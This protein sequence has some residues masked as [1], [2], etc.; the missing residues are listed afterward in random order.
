[1]AHLFCE[2][3]I[4]SLQTYMNSN[5]QHAGFAVKTCCLRNCRFGVVCFVVV[6]V[7]VREA[8]ACWVCVQSSFALTKCH[9]TYGQMFLAI[10]VV[11][12]RINSEQDR[13]TF[14][15]RL[16][17]TTLLLVVLSRRFKQRFVGVGS[18]DS[19]FSADSKNSR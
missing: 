5:L 2:I 3:F 15:N 7:V 4:D 18:K 14:K 13:T 12:D 10:T 1:M 6:V 17:D 9:W 8:S 19:L 16:D 11:S